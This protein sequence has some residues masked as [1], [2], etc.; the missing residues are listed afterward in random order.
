M[1]TSMPRCLMFRRRN[2]KKQNPT[3]MKERRLNDSAAMRWG[4]LGVVSFTMMAAYFPDDYLPILPQLKV[5]KYVTKDFPP[6]FV[7]SAQNDYLKMMAKPMWRI[8]QKKGVE[9]EL[10]IYGTKEQKEVGHVF[11]VNCKLPI[12]AECNDDECAFFRNHLR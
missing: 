7:M 8:L 6:A 3:T 10:R 12:A 1:A 11:H 4:A 2:K 5:K 9:S